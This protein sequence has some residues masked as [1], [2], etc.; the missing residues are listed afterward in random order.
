MI[1]L[2]SKQRKRIIIYIFLIIYRLYS[3][4]RFSCCMNSYKFKLFLLLLMNTT[5]QLQ[6]YYTILINNENFTNISLYF[7]YLV[8]QCQN[9]SLQVYNI[10]NKK[11][12]QLNQRNT[13]DQSNILFIYNELL[14]YTYID[15]EYKFHIYIKKLTIQIGRFY[16]ICVIF[17]ID[18]FQ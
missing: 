2:I 10:L 6:Y 13:S 18:Y 4:I 11:G 15:I 14:A 3:I 1:L 17:L 9:K 12:K 8:A 5:N 7:Y 16:V